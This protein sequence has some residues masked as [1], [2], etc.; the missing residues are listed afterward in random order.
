M[1]TT[2][3]T[4]REALRRFAA[5][6]DWDQFHSPKNLAMA[7]NVEAGELL[8]QFQW[9]SEAQSQALS[10]EQHQA[11]AEEIADVLLY[12]IRLADRLG[13]DPLD[14]AA[15]KMVQNARKYPVDKAK[16]RA[17]KYTQL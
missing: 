5:E 9:L 6:R 1:N 13:I 16:G 11:V 15:Q 14:A 12:L 3:D 7:L 2:L 4:L 10:P 8:E 17:D